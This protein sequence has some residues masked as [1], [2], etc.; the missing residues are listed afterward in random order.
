MAITM[1]DIMSPATACLTAADP[2]V[3]AAPPGL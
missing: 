1:R 3:A 2:A